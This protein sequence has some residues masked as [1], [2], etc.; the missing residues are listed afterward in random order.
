M[1][2]MHGQSEEAISASSVLVATDVP[3]REHRGESGYTPRQCRTD[4]ETLVRAK[5]PLYNRPQLQSALSRVLR[6]GDTTS[7]RL[8]QLGPYTDAGCTWSQGVGL[9]IR[10]V[11]F[12]SRLGISSML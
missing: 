6:G 7:R 5:L 3:N 9:T 10:Q 2:R 1:S 11:L 4:S 8:A 12:C